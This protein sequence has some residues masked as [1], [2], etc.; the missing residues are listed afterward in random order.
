MQVYPYCLDRDRVRPG[1]G[2]IA[3][4]SVSRRE[5]RFGYNWAG[6]WIKATNSQIRTRP[7]DGI[8]KNYDL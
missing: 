6:R 5:K 7:I 3:D 4:Q 1:A 2:H 8:Y